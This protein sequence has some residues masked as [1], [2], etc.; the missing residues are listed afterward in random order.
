MLYHMNVRRNIC[1]INIGK[2]KGTWFFCKI[3]FPTEEKMLP[4]LMTNN[5][6]IDEDLFNQANVKIELDIKEEDEVKK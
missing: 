2:N 6:A 3:P 4:V 5:H 1:K